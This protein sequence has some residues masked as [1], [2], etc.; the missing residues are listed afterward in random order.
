MLWPGRLSSGAKS[1]LYTLEA[2]LSYSSAKRTREVWPA[3][4]ARRWVVELAAELVVVGESE[5]VGDEVDEE[6]DLR[7]RKGLRRE[8]L[9]RLD[10]VLEADETDEALA[11]LPEV[12]LRLGLGRLVSTVGV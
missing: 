11:V 10:E 5:S 8:S 2:S 1:V 4:R 9:E 7:R 6:L 12:A 3:G